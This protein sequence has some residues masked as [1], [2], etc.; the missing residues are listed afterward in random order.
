MKWP[1]TRP[2]V[3]ITRSVEDR[4]RA[5]FTYFDTQATKYRWAFYLLGLI[6]LIGSIFVT[7]SAFAGAD[8]LVFQVTG[9]AVAVSTILFTFFKVQE[10]YV[11]NRDTAERIDRALRAF[12]NVRRRVLRGGGTEMDADSAAEEW[13]ERQE[14]AI[15]ERE[16]GAWVKAAGETTVDAAVRPEKH[17]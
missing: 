11:R 9:S 13:L 17:Q 16:A 5:D 10:N 7:G 3:D 14:E 4:L 12:G 15:L 1:G 8:E 6:I 2:P